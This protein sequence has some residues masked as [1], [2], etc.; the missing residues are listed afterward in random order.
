M[1]QIDRHIA[2][3]DWIGRSSIDRPPSSE[4]DK[5]AEIGDLW[6]ILTVRR[7]WV[8]GTAALLT[9]IA[10]AYGFL[11]PPLYAA[12]A[13]IL[14]D[15]RDKQIVT[16]DVN[17]VAM[18][19]D[20]GVMQVESQA[21]VIESDSVLTRAARDAGL[22]DDP[23]FGGVG[24]GFLSW[25]LRT[26]QGEGAAPATDAAAEARAVRAL[27]R[28]LAV[29]RADK[30]FVVD[31]VVTAGNPDK[32]ARIVNAIAA[33][34]LK[35]Q[36]S[37][38]ADAASR[39]SSEMA[40][41]LDDLRKR[42]NV[43]ENKVET[44]KAE[45]G[46]ITASGQLI[47]E[48]QLAESNNRI[49]AARARTAEARTRLQQI[50]DARG[51]TAFGPDTAPEAIQSAVIERLRSQYAELASKEADLRTQLGNRH[52]FIEA[53]RTQ[54][55]D[56]KRLTETEL[57]RIARSAETDYQ[58][59]VANEKALTANLDELKRG[60]I[61]TGEASVRLRELE[62]EVDTSRAVYSNFLNRSREIQ[63]Q[64]GIDTTNARVI[65]WAR[66]PAERSWPLRLLLF[67]GGLVSGLGLG[68]GLAFVREYLD[69]TVLSR[70][71]ME[72]LSHTSVVATYPEFK[73]GS[74]RPASVA[75]SLTLDRLASVR[76]QIHPPGQA[77][78]VLVTSAASDTADRRS[79]IHLLA[80]VA[81]A[82]GERVLVVEADLEATPEE[83][84]SG[85]GLIEVL[86]G[87]V[88]MAAA[89][90]ADAE[91]GAARIG[92]GDLAK[93]SR[94]ALSRANIEQFLAAAKSSFDL[95]LI[96]GGVL[97][98]NLRIGPLAAA[99]DRLLIVAK[100]GATR[101]RDLLDILDISEVLGRPVSGSLFVDRYAAAA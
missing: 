20:G 92:I 13:Q 19:P 91:S 101:Q 93:A 11:A 97:T 89:A 55:Q 21:R 43:A 74:E 83:N 18:A 72:R 24:T 57:T 85:P 82:R 35:D 15:P 2:A 27:R 94:E 10:V 71:Q 33:A 66:P 9:F 51:S 36:T 39:A 90:K 63:E 22:L 3:A 64:T 68:A 41:R 60:S 47:S 87:E 31:V 95:I 12:T 7:A 53:V 77:L 44:F 76:G 16:N 29:K 34:Y 50:K 88:G 86:R 4:P 42:V 46:L 62:R 8:L 32:A 49:V 81:T 61:V 73:A 75:A 45:N 99:S 70:R 28:R 5:S 79:T 37:A 25:T 52:P 14:I 26:L 23:D 56:V 67:V 80:A 84:A 30:V 78:S 58:R 1:A 100:N 59:A 69:P 6:R 54:M 17:P 48:Q 98:G 65:S 40:S 38:R 96:D